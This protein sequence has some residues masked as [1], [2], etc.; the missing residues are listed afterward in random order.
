M[1]NPLQ[2]E[3]IDALDRRAQDLDGATLSRLRRARAE[4]IDQAQSASLLQGRSGWGLAAAG[5]VTSLLLVTALLPG[6]F[7]STAPAEADDDLLE[8]A[9]L[10]VD[11][12]VVEHL[13]FYEW[14]SEQ[15]LEE[16]LGDDT[17]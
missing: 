7:R 14:L 9:T 6:L 17:A 3:L 2:Q 4:A 10:D 13:E 16:T 15:N 12:E 11:L 1:K 5:L 8:I